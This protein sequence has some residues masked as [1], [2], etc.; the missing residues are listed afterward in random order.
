MR[1]GNALVMLKI[2]AFTL[3]GFHIYHLCSLPSAEPALS[4]ITA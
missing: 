2:S 1:C 3:C 4:I